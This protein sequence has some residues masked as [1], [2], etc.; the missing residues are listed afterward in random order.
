MT[1]GESA[2]KVREDAGLSVHMLSKLSGVPVSTIQFL[3]YEQGAGNG[4]GLRTVVDL[5]D[6]LGV[7]IDTYIGHDCACSNTS[8]LPKRYGELA[9]DMTKVRDL[10]HQAVKI[11][12]AWR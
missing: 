1:W 3:E 4:P 9:Q 12:G 10:L 5:A 2:R 11:T 7:S 8:G 6:A